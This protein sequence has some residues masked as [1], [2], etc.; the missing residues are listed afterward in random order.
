MTF[1][2]KLYFTQTYKNMYFQIQRDLSVALWIKLLE[3]S[4][5]QVFKNRSL[6]FGL[7]KSKMSNYSDERTWNL[8]IFETEEEVEMDLKHF[9]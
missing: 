4:I 5:L 9:L 7:T 6:C 3:A 1:M 8:S 2:E